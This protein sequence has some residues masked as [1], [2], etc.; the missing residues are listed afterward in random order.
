M[1]SMC[2]F[3]FRILGFRFDD[4]PAQVNVNEVQVSLRHP[5]AQFGKD[6][7]DQMIALRVRVAEGAA[8]KDADG[9]P[10]LWRQY[11]SISSGA[12]FKGRRYSQSSCLARRGVASAIPDSQRNH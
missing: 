4:S 2:C 8:D 5:V 12:V 1:T 6:H 7:L 9:F 11:R 10:G 3:V